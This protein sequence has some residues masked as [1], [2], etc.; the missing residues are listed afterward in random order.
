MRKNSSMRAARPQ[1]N[2]RMAPEPALTLEDIA[3]LEEFIAAVG[4]EA[5][6][7][8]SAEELLKSLLSTGGRPEPRN[9][10][11]QALLA[12]LATALDETRLSANSGDRD[13]RRELRAVQVLL[14][15]ALQSGAVHPVL[16][17][18]LG[19]IFAG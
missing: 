12:A 11:H 1:Q 17:V 9:D 19:R 16:L 10:E 3:T 6:D 8:E 14:D 18:V 4:A 2:R 7:K 13:A 15:R 5:D